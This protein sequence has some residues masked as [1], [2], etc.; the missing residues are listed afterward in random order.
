MFARCSRAIEIL[1]LVCFTLSL[2]A[3]AEREPSH[4]E[5]ANRLYEEGKYTEA[6]CLYEATVRAGRHSPGVFFNLGNAYFK[7]GELGRAIYNFRRA[8]ALAP[9]D[10]DIQANLRFARERI[11]G[12]AA[13]QIPLWR[14][15]VGIF[16]LN[17]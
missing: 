3:A 13:V 5:Q 15:Y 1:V 2:S 9:R 12:S 4:F 7:S 8:E 14:R 10:P 16:T 17:E 6:I 11:S